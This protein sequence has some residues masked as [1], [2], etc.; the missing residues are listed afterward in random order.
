[1]RSGNPHTVWHPFGCVAHRWM[2]RSFWCEGG[3]RIGVD[4]YSAVGRRHDVCVFFFGAT[5]ALLLLR[6]SIRNFVWVCELAQLSP[7][8]DNV[9]RERKNIL[10]T[11]SV[12]LFP[13]LRMGHVSIR[14]IP[15]WNYHWRSM[16]MG[17]WQMETPNSGCAK[18][19]VTMMRTG[20]GLTEDWVDTRSARLTYMTRFASHLCTCSARFRNAHAHSDT[21]FGARLDTFEHAHSTHETI[22]AWAHISSLSHSTG[23]QS[24]RSARSE[25]FSDRF[26]AVLSTIAQNSKALHTETRYMLGSAIL[27]VCIMLRYLRSIHNVWCTRAIMR[28]PCDGKHHRQRV[29][30]GAKQQHDGQVPCCVHVGPKEGVYILTIM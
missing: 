9:T 22:C 23:A 4:D 11:Q 24:L 3:G 30:S 29:W 14:M 15:D 16:V 5:I 8:F 17:S 27:H 13:I 12:H 28:L 21:Q 26:S 1:M 19:S 25:R 2:W 7:T 10:S 20:H 6:C 18:R